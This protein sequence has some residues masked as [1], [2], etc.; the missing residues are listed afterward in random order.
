[1]PAPGALT[2]VVADAGAA[3]PPW[4]CCNPVRLNL[5]DGDARR[6]LV[7]VPGSLPDLL[8]Y[9]QPDEPSSPDGLGRMDNITGYLGTE[10][11]AGACLLVR[12]LGYR[13][14]WFMM[15]QFGFA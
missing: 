14:I 10:R 7:G 9:A 11:R 2:V 4:F 8:L 5:L 12:L 3:A 13:L 6:Q 15:P 1:M